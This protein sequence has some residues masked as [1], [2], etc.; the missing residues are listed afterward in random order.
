MRNLFVFHQWTIY[1]AE[2]VSRMAQL[3]LDQVTLSILL[4]LHS[5][6]EPTPT[7]KYQAI[8]RERER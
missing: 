1:N 4:I 3:T 5:K 2:G 6:L 8:S 7:E